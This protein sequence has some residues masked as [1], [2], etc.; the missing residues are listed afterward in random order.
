MATEASR[1]Y[2][3]F[4]RPL[5][6]GVQVELHN[7][8]PIIFTILD[9]RPVVDPRQPAGLRQVDLTVTLPLVVMNGSP[10]DSLTAVVYP[11]AQDV[12]KRP[13]GQLDALPPASQDNESEAGSDE[14]IP[15]G[16]EGKRPS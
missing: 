12:D 5:F 11:K 10:I 15:P 7:S 8:L 14:Y 9:I 1:I 13:P 6:P 3:R 4:R 16:E 2:D